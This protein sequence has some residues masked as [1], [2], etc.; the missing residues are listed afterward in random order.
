[1]I[2]ELVL[3]DWYES[4]GEEVRERV[5]YRKFIFSVIKVQKFAFGVQK[6]IKLYIRKQTQNTVICPAVII[7]SVLQR[8]DYHRNYI[9]NSCE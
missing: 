6:E 8:Q 2:T 3:K 7:E 5:S 9:K 4:S 1:M